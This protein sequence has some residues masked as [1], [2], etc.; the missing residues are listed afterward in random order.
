[1]SE[2]GWVKLTGRSPRTLAV[3]DTVTFAPGEVLIAL[4]VTKTLAREATQF[5]EPAL[6]RDLW[7]DLLIEDL[8]ASAPSILSAPD[9]LRRAGGHARFH[10]GPFKL[11]DI[12]IAAA[13]TRRAGP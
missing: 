7:A 2:A 10:Y 11:T 4:A 13:V 3:G 8:V 6:P 1:M 12:E 9:A 5:L